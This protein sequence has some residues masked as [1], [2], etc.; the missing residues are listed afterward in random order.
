M[1]MN[2]ETQKG[3]SLIDWTL[4]IL[5]IVVTVVLIGVYYNPFGFLSNK[6][7]VPETGAIDRSGEVKQQLAAQRKQIEAL[8]RKLDQATQPVGFNLAS[9]HKPTAKAKTAADKEIAELRRDKAKKAKAGARHKAEVQRLA[10]EQAIKNACGKL[11]VMRD[12]RGKLVCIPAPK[13]AKAPSK[14]EKC[15]EGWVYDPETKGLK[16][17]KPPVKESVAVNT[18]PQNPCASVGGVPEIRIV[19]GKQSTW[20]VGVPVAEAPNDSGVQATVV[21]VVMAGVLGQ[22]IKPSG[23]GLQ[24]VG[25]SVL[26]H[27]GLRPAGVAAKIAECGFGP[28]AIVAMRKNWIGGGS[29]NNQAGN[30]GGPVES[31][32]P[33]GPVESPLRVLTR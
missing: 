31:P 7:D 24:G 8:K 26:C 30:I 9:G 1:E 28:P 21:S 22:A 19:D 2:I 27:M 16:C 5:V 10:E 32:E 25:L 14:K 23:G 15:E 29:N 20:C 33:G 12:A 13:A 3:A 6:N 18:P 4:R 11:G 17:P